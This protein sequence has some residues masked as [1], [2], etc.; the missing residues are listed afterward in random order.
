MKRNLMI[1]LL[2]V[3][4]WGSTVTL[5][6][7]VGCPDDA[8]KKNVETLWAMA[9]RGELLTTDGWRLASGYF[10][11]PGPPDSDKV[12]QVVSNYFGVNNYS[13]DGTIAMVEMEYTDEGQINAVL[14]YRPP[15]ETHADK[16]SLRYR[17]VSGPSYMVTYGPDGK[18]KVQEKE[19]PGKK[20]WLVQGPP[21]AP[22]ATVNAAIRYLLEMREKATDPAIKENADQTLTILLRFH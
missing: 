2:F 19:I 13:N 7:T 14:R 18:T 5:S 16:T 10:S 3:S 9:T 21:P 15:H 8:P 22:W 6:Q 1:A 17:L 11:K 4:T 20:A 12:V